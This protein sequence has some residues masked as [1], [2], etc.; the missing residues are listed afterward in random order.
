MWE[1][2]R[3]S[4]KQNKIQ[5]I[6]NEQCNVVMWI[7]AWNGFASNAI[8][9]TAGTVAVFVLFGVIFFSQKKVTKKKESDWMEQAYWM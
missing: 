9:C 8:V 3:K 7:V 2:A 4:E 1:W 5:E 6:R